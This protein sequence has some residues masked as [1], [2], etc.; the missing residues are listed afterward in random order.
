MGGGWGSVRWGCQMAPLIASLSTSVETIIGGMTLYVNPLSQSRKQE[1]AQGFCLQLSPSCCSLTIGRS[2]QLNPRLHRPQGLVRPLEQLLAVH[3][4]GGPV[5]HIVEAS[6]GL[7]KG[8][9]YKSLDLSQGSEF[10]GSGS[11]GVCP[12]DERTVIGGRAS[13]PCPSDP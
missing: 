10:G 3:G 8:G 11:H 7:L 4:N 5:G 9:T 2:H 12:D 13:S 6:T 1:A